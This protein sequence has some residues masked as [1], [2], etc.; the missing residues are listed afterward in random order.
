MKAGAP[1]FAYALLLALFVAVNTLPGYRG[2]GTYYTASRLLL[3]GEVGPRLYD[4]E[5]MRG[6]IVAETQ[7]R[8]SDIFTP[9]APTATLL[10]LPVALLSPPMARRVWAALNTIILAGTIALLLVHMA[11]QP[12]SGAARRGSPADL[13]SGRAPAANLLRPLPLLLA[14]AFGLFAAPVADGF[15]E[16]HHSCDGASHAIRVAHGWHHW[17]HCR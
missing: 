9:N 8:V 12:E 1:W 14:L 6:Q 4:D 13:A 10:A 7:G 3:R 11:R 16:S 5:W 17:H 15:R 2:D